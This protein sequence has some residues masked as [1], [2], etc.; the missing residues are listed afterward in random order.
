LVGYGGIEDK[1]IGCIADIL[2]VEEGFGCASEGDLK[3]IPV[4]WDSSRSI[5]EFKFVLSGNAPVK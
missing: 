5:E 4:V 3:D 2:R 1:T